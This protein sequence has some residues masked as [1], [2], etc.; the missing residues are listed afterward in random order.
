MHYQL[1]YDKC[2]N[3]DVFFLKKSDEWITGV[4]MILRFSFIFFSAKEGNSNYEQTIQLRNT[5]SNL[6]DLIK[7]SYENKSKVFSFSEHPEIKGKYE[8]IGYTK[9]IVEDKESTLA[10]VVSI[11]KFEFD[12]IIEK[13]GHCFHSDSNLQNLS[14]SWNEISK[15]EEGAI[16]ENTRERY[17]NP[18]INTLERN[19]NIEINNHE[20]VLSDRSGVTSMK[21]EYRSQCLH[22]MNEIELLNNQKDFFLNYETYE[23]DSIRDSYIKLINEWSRFTKFIQKNEI[24]NHE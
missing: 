15:I 2:L 1:S 5:R 12:Y 13:Y 6:A 18:L 16:V 23:Q 11:S 9:H 19:L 17:S 24:Y 8:I 10:T 21:D 14:Y 22:F 20:K 4:S 3:S 7:V